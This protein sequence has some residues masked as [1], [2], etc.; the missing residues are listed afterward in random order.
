MDKDELLA[1]VKLLV[2]LSD[3]D[4]KAYAAALSDIIGLSNRYALRFKD[5]Y[6]ALNPLVELYKDDVGVYNDVLQMI[7]KR[8]KDNVFSVRQRHYMTEFM[9]EKRARERRA[10][11]IENAKRPESQKLQGSARLNFMRMKSNEWNDRR[12]TMLNKAREQCGGRLTLERQQELAE[13]FW[14]QIDA[15]LDAAE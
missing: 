9:R 13:M 4:A 14:K 6:A 15:E 10:V 5:R 12:T 3:F 2:G 7:S 1:T 8:R 11:D